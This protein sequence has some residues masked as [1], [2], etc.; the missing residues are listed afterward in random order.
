MIAKKNSRLNLERKRFVFFNVG[1]L[2]AGSFTLAAFTYETPLEKDLLSYDVAPSQVEYVV[3]YDKPEPKEEVV[4]Q[5]P[6]QQQEEQSQQ[7]VGSQNAVTE[8]T[9]STVNSSTTPEAGIGA[10]SPPGDGLFIPKVKAKIGPAP[11]VEIPDIEAEYIGG[12]GA[13]KSHIFDVMNYPED[14]RE[15]GEQGRVYVSFIVEK[16]GSLTDVKIVDGQGAYRSLDREAKRIV[17]S[18]PLWKPGEDAYG[19]VRT[20]VVLPISFILQE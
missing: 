6:V 5:S 14:A 15:L 10:I 16:D 1:L 9:S 3:D 12:I 19:V 18:F 8:H 11:V 20:K 17:R 7:Q 13:M 2:T 4:R